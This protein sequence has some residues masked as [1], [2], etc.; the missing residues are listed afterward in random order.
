MSVRDLIP[1]G[2]DRSPG[3]RGG[4][5]LDP[6]LS[7][8]RDVNRLFDDF[9]GGFGVR[10]PAAGFGGPGWPQTDVAET[11]REYRVTAELP[12]LEEKDIDLTFQDGVLTLKGEKK[13]EHGGEGARYSERYHGRFQRSISLGPDVEEDKVSASFRNGVLTV[14][15]PKSPEAETRVK[16]IAINGR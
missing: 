4:E 14:V 13:V 8:H 6:I 2:R 11:D 3:V 1:W 10:L 15:L 12:G 7:L 5:T 9:F 16:R